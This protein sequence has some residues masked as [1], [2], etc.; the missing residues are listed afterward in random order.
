VA[1]STASVKKLQKEDIFETSMQKPITTDFCTVIAV[2][3]QNLF[4]N[5]VR[6]G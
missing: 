1:P 2:I 3:C 4:F 5:F 6:T